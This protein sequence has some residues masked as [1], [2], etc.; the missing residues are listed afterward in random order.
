MIAQ[1]RSA[2]YSWE[3][4]AAKALQRTVS[5][6]SIRIAAEGAVEQFEVVT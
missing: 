5:F 2:A 3:K 6:S 1:F 4:S